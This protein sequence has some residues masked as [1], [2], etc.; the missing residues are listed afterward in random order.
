MVPKNGSEKLIARIVYKG[1]VRRAGA[2]RPAG[3]GRQGVARRQCRHG[4]A[5]LCGGSGRHR[6]DRAPRDRRAS[7]LVIGMFRASA[8]KL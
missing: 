5:G 6:L 8:E 2:I 7:E 3:R 4:S 1:P